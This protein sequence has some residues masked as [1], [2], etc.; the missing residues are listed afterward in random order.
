MKKF[1]IFLAV[2]LAAILVL[3]ACSP[4]TTTEQPVPTLQETPFATTAPGV[5]PTTG[6]GLPTSGAP[7][8]PAIGTP[9]ATTMAT[10]GPVMGATG[11]P[12]GG[13]IGTPAGTPAATSAPGA[14]LNQPWRMTNL[15]SSR[16]LTNTCTEVGTVANVIVDQ[17]SG[18]IR[19]LNVDT[20]AASG[21]TGKMVLVPW[22]AT[23]LNQVPTGAGT[24]VGPSVGTPAAGTAAPIVSTP[25]ATG[26]PIAATPMATLPA[27]N[28]PAPGT[29]GQANC[30]GEQQAI[31]L[32][33]GQDV[34]AAAPQLT[35]LPDMTAADWDTDIRAYWGNQL[36]LLP[37][38]GEAPSAQVGEIDSVTGMTL[39]GTGGENFGPIQEIV[40]NTDTGDVSHLIWFPGGILTFNNGV[41][42]VP[43]NAVIW[44][45]NA[46]TFTLKMNVSPSQLE[47][48]PTFPSV[49]QLP[50]PMQNPDWAQSADTFWSNLG[51]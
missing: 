33:I 2:S 9:M 27:V 28:T 7:T 30:P 19:Y 40:I 42:A 13:L 51:Q 20:S 47:Q 49:D 16:V 1:S 48:A 3:A 36:G 18:H 43:W 15:L 29:A 34:F 8:L 24:S 11:T 10:Q 44:D 6:P 37:V 25:S 38:T 41:V 4:A 39:H 5:L 22:G 45:P 21:G 46:N 17:V 35:E 14:A 31:V 26:T 50:D 12:A 32:T 23:A